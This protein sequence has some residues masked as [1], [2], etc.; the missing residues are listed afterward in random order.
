MDRTQHQFYKPWQ[1]G[2]FPKKRSDLQ[3]LKY[4]DDGLEIDLIFY[5]PNQTITVKFAYTEVYRVID[6][7]RRLKQLQ[8]L[9]LPM[10]ETVYVV[11]NS[12][13]VEELVDESCGMLKTR[14]LVHYFIVTDNDCI[15]V[16]TKADFKPQLGK[17][18]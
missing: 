4:S 12:D 11:S 15:D 16:I 8:H 13:I 17:K 7:G 14:D 6:E 5:D 9:P 1:I 18:C 3:L 10:E 2:A